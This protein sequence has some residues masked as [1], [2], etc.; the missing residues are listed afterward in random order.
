V[1]GAKEEIVVAGRQGGEDS[2]TQSDY[3]QGLIVDHL[4]NIY[5]ADSRCFIEIFPTLI[6]YR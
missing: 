4:C 5:V 1:K 6:I 3:P 2:L